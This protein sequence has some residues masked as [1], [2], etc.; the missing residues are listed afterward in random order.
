[1]YAIFFNSRVETIQ[2]AISRGKMIT[3]KLYRRLAMKK[4]IKN[5]VKKSR[6]RLCLQ[7]LTLLHDVV[8]ADTSKGTFAFLRRKA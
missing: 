8:P 1:M 3:G 2:V 6:T 5:Y 7:S 4:K